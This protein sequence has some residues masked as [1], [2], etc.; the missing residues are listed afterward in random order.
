MS[1]LSVFVTFFNCIKSNTSCV[2][3]Y[4]LIGRFVIE[5]IDATVSALAV[6]ELAR[7]QYFVS[8]FTAF[9]AQSDI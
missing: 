1:K 9:V 5:F 4:V 2:V 6:A 8:E 3:Q 7:T